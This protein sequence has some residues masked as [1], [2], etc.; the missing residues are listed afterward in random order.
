VIEVPSGE[1]QR[2]RA[3]SKAGKQAWL[4]PLQAVVSSKESRHAITLR[5]PSNKFSSSF[6]APNSMQGTTFEQVETQECPWRTARETRTRDQ[7]EIERD[8]DVRLLGVWG[9]WSPRLYKSEVIMVQ[10]F[11]SLF[12]L[13]IIYPIAWNMFCTDLWMTRNPLMI[14]INRFAVTE[15]HHLSAVP[16][17]SWREL[18]TSSQDM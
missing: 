17:S 12:H 14:E 11:F 1:S 16:P 10:L 8:R 9:T 15:S 5:L 3:D 2:W 7:R 18:S 13:F 4:T 6:S